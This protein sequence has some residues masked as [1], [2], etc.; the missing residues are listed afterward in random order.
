MTEEV[1]IKYVKYC[2]TKREYHEVS[3]DNLDDWTTTDFENNGMFESLLKLEYVRLYFDIDFHDL[4]TE[5]PTAPSGLRGN[6]N[7][8]V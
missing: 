8:N 1:M 2:G 5:A 6:V 4:L 7:S 3:H